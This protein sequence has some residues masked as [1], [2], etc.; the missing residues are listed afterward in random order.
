MRQP[1]SDEE[2]TGRSDGAGQANPAATLS[3][4]RLVAVPDSAA[5]P[6]AHKVLSTI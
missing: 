6:H 3:L 5:A 4:P 2:A 1:G